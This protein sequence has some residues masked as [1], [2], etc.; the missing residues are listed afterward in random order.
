MVLLKWDNIIDG[1]IEFNRS[2]TKKFFSIKIMPPVR[3]ILRFYKRHNEGNPY[4]FPI[5]KKNTICISVYSFV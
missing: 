2:K 4:I 5:F 3:K 1:R